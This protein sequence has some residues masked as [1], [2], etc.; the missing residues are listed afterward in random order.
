MFRPKKNSLWFLVSAHV[1]FGS[2]FIFVAMKQCPIAAKIAR[3]MNLGN[4][5]EYNVL[6]QILEASFGPT[7]IK[8]SL[9]YS[10]TRHGSVILVSLILKELYWMMFLLFYLVPY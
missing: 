7:L 6:D 2:L 3:K 8:K 10:A 5:P 9:K 4:H 1:M